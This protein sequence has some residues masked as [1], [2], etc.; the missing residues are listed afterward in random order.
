M[1]KKPFPMREGEQAGGLRY[2]EFPMARRAVPSAELLERGI[3]KEGEDG[4]ML[5]EV[6][7]SSE[8]EIE[9]WFGIEILSHA[10]GAVDMTRINGG[11]AVLVD[12][13]GDQ[14]GKVMNGTARIDEDRVQRAWLRF[15]RSA[16]GQEI[17]GD[18]ADQTRENISVGYMVLDWDVELRETGKD[19][20]G[21]PTYTEVYRVTRWQPA[22]VSIVSVP[23]DVTVGVGRS[24]PVPGFPEARAEAA[25]AAGKG[26]RNMEPEKKEPGSILIED[27]RSETEKARDKD[28]AEIFRI[29]DAN[30]LGARAPEYIEQGLTVDQVCHEIIKLRRT[31]RSQGDPAPI[32]GDVMKGLRL[33]DRRRFRYS[34]AILIASGDEK[35][36]GVEAEVHQ[37]LAKHYMRSGLSMHSKSTL[38]PLDLRT[39]EEY[40][41]DLERRTLDTKTVTKGNE[42]VF[43]QSGELIELLRNRSAIVALGARTLTGLSGPISFP[44]QTGAGTA[45]W[46]GE[47]PAT[48]LV[49]SDLTLG[50]VQMQ[51]RTIQS[52]TAYARQLLVQASIDVENLVRNDLALIHALAWDRAGIH[53]LSSAGQP[54]GIYYAPDVQMK[55]QSGVPDYIKLVDQAALVADKNADEG[56]LGWITTPL[57]AGKLKTL[58]EH[59]T[60]TM[61]NWIWQGTFREGTVVGYPARATNQVSK[62]LTNSVEGAGAQHGI[63]FGNWADMIVGMF[64]GGIEIIVDPY[65]KKKRAMIEVTSFQ[66]VD[67]ILRHGE[68]FAKSHGATLS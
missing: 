2:A 40:W 45:S 54:V 30:G 47:S 55:D 67:I 51:P 1:D 66:M 9:R 46:V 19:G 41:Q 6:A 39:P 34:R 43:E 38:I 68:S 49:D 52:T 58:P 4:R 11:A 36:D 25:V 12:H 65:A 16:R 31:P 62:T 53:G 18:V 63:V 35:F 24:I 44:K 13:R 10:K 7:I 8:S 50:L 26:Q 22:E 32:G 20:N 60:G 3:A 5:Y 14:V 23:A 56:A 29:C 48:D 17:E 37:E 28:R 33:S 61:A 15:S 64:G 42:V 57:M 27:Q 59:A 21:K